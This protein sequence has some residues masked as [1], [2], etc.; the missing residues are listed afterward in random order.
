[1]KRFSELLLN[2]IYTTSRNDKITHIMNWISGSDTEEIGWGLSVICQELEIPKVKS[3]MVKEISFSHL[4]KYLFELSYDYVGDMA[5]TISL[6]WPE[7]INKE[8]KFNQASLSQVIKDLKT[9]T[10]SEAPELI[11]NY[12]NN[13]D[14][15]TRW[16]FLKI[17]TGGLRVGVSSRIAKIALS[18]SFNKD[19]NE[20]EELWHAFNPPYRELIEW[21]NGKTEKPNVQNRAIFRSPMLANPLEESDHKLINPTTYLAEWKWDGIRIQLVSSNGNVKLYSRTGDDISKS[22]PEISS[23]KFKQNF[24][25]DG[26]LMA[27]EIQ[28]PGTF[29]NL[30]QRLNRKN[31]SKE[32]INSVPT[33]IIA[34]DLLILDKIDLRSKNILERRKKLETF[35][36]I[37]K[38]PFIKY[39]EEVSYR[40]FD[41]LEKKRLKCR[42]DFNYEGLMLKSKVSDY[43]TGRPKG[44]WYKFKRDPFNIDA[45]LLYAQRGHGKRSSL[46]SDYTFGVWKNSS[47]NKEL[48]TV[49]KAYSGFTDKELIRLDK[50]IRTKTIGRFGPV[51]EVEK[52]LVLEVSFDDIQKSKRHKSG[53]AMRFPRIKRIRWDK[54]ACEADTLETLEKLA[55]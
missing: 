23:F 42:E 19:I 24:S 37:G 1:M 38:F 25:L 46:Y 4:D 13:F 9:I 44:P 14:Q 10:K 52:S 16:T 31:P 45:V 35:L 55:N 21:I 43:Q 7:E 15:N 11:T 29:N 20:I 3:S 32:I 12:L 34:Y 6:I 54:P 36:K 53:L 2:L 41:D 50:F 17:I 26:E 8:K 49:G 27:G 30:Q 51:R 33:F 39:S 28:N 47:S 40:N 18:K 48:V 5:E 22:F